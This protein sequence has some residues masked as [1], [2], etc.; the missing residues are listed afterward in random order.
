MVTAD[1]LGDDDDA[2]R[3]ARSALLLLL[4]LPGTPP[5]FP[6]GACFVPY[7]KLLVVS[8]A[9]SGVSAHCTYYRCRTCSGPPKTGLLFIVAAASQRLV[10]CRAPLIYKLKRSWRN[11]RSPRHSPVIDDVEIFNIKSRAVACVGI[12]KGGVRFSLPQYSLFPICY[13]V[14]LR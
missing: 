3:G 13:T 4:L 8:S 14:F 12:S 1:A 2:G 7:T 11:R 9:M 5:A 10:L 6:I